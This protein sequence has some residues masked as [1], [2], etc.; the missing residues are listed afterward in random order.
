MRRAWSFTILGAEER[1]GILY[2][3]LWVFVA[4]A[5]AASLIK[6]IGNFFPV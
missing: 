3:L 4:V 2:A 1:G 6:V 5:V